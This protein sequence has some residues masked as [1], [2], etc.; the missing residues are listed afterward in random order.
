M[1]EGTRCGDLGDTT[2]YTGGRDTTG[3]HTEGYWRKSKPDQ[4]VE[5]ARKQ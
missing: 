1:N 2:S 3:S 5:E 4:G